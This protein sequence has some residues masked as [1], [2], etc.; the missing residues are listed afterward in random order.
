MSPLSQ[1]LEQGIF[2]LEKKMRG[3][4]RGRVIKFVRSAVA[5]QGSD[6]GHGHGTTRQAMLRRRPTSHN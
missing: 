6:P 4:L 5:A 3:W 1:D 2:D